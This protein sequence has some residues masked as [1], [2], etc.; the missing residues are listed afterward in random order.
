[1]DGCD[2]QF[3]TDQERRAWM[4][5]AVRIVG[6]VGEILQSGTGK[7]SLVGGDPGENRK[8]SGGPGPT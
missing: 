8:Q 6:E 5:P 1:M 4:A 3:R 7:L 2:S